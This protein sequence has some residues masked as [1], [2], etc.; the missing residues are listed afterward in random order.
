MDC[1]EYME[2]AAIWGRYGAADEI[3]YRPR[4]RQR[5]VRLEIEGTPGRF[6]SEVNQE[7]GLVQS[8]E[9]Y[10]AMGRSPRKERWDTV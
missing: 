9:E 8:Y 1:V 2:R 10:P 5:D 4:F 3:P 6:F 7:L